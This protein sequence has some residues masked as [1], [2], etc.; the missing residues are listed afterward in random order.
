[1]KET[2]HVSLASQA[3][4]FDEDAYRS[5]KAYLSAIEQRLPKDD[6]ETLS[7]V[8]VRM[9]EIL[10]TKTPSPMLVVT[11]AMVQQARAQMG[12]PAEFGDDA[13]T[14]EETPRRL[15]RSND[16]TIAGICGGLADYLD[17]DPTLVRV[18][19]L[20][21]ILLGGLSIWIYII[22]W[23]IIPSDPKVPQ[24]QKRHVG[25]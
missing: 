14:S 18:V 17:L 12:E 20:L 9:A 15:Y 4:I 8:E 1:M 16:R 3:F 2:V 19:T 13:R 25:R 5:L 23:I 10:R 7:D 24:N 6:H 22:L 21:L 11:L